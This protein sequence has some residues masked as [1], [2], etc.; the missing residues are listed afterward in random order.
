MSLKCGLSPDAI[1]SAHGGTSRPQ[2]RRKLSAAESAD[3]RRLSGAARLFDG[4]YAGV[5]STAS[6]G[7]FEIL[8]VTDGRTAVLVTSGN[9]S[10]AKGPRKELLDWL[11][12][13]E[14]ALRKDRSTLDEEKR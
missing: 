8:T 11:H 1:G 7:T 10:F 13:Q 12:R 3:L 2:R 6:D 4:G 5:E 9:P 14:E